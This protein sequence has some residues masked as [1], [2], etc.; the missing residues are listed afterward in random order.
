MMPITR[1]ATLSLN[2]LVT[3]Y[4]IKSYTPARW[5]EF[6]RSIHRVVKETKYIPALD[7][8]YQ[9]QD[10]LKRPTRMFLLYSETL[11]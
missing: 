6:E 1:A 4:R 7:P 5:E 9:A 11:N 3:E 10:L 8:I 2:F